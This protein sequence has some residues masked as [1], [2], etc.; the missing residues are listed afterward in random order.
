MLD[1]LL[2]D[3]MSEARLRNHLPPF[4][5]PLYLDYARLPATHLGDD[6]PTKMYLVQL[7]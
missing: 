1:R 6:D 4:E 7:P 3:E 2:Y 5:P